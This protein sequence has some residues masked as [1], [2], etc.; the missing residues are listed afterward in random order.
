[1]LNLLIL[2]T[3]GFNLGI[4]GGMD[5]VLAWKLLNPWSYGSPGVAGERGMWIWRSWTLWF[6]LGG[7]LSWYLP[8]LGFHT[9]T[10]QLNH[11]VQAGSRVSL[12]L[13]TLGFYLIT[14][15]F[16]FIMI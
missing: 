3:L 11:L 16:I 7:I 4:M 15:F 6:P 1:M 2:G 12:I 9:W 10:P 5:L 14:I 13:A 8:T